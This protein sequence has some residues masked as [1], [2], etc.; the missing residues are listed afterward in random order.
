LVFVQLLAASNPIKNTCIVLA[1]L[2][3]GFEAGAWITLIERLLARCM[4]KQQRSAGSV[5]TPG[6]QTNHFVNMVLLAV[7]LFLVAITQVYTSLNTSLGVAPGLSPPSFVQATINVRSYCMDPRPGYNQAR[8]DTLTVYSGVLG[9]TL[10]A[11]PGWLMPVQ[12]DGSRGMPPM[13]PFTGSCAGL[14]VDVP[15]TDGNSLSLLQRT[16]P[17]ERAHDV[18][19]FSKM[20][21]LTTNATTGQ[22]ATVMLTAAPGPDCTSTQC[23]A[24]CA[25]EAC[26]QIFGGGGV[27]VQQ[28]AY[29]VAV[30]ARGSSVCDLSGTP[31]APN[32]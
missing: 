12:A 2:Y 1:A 8:W 13:P 5:L 10:H 31:A 28:L 26:T 15:G 27:P 17:T 25:S 23:T 4:C 18:I 6:W 7:I 21:R 22:T 11:P 24:Y 3:L 20:L 16:N 9:Q 30:T 19:S 14:V 29:E 32:P